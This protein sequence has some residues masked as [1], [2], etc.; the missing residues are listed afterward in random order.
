[1]FNWK[2]CHRRLY[3]DMERDLAYANYAGDL[4]KIEDKYS[5]NVFWVLSDKECPKPSE[6]PCTN[7]P[8]PVT[9]K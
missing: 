5:R 4:K 2:I 7:C 8:N 1:M 3:D 6:E 9:R